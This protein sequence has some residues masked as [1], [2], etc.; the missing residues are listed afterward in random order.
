MCLHKLLTMNGRQWLGFSL[1]VLSCVAW[2]VMP[3]LAFFSLE[4]ERLAVYI[5]GLF[6]FA[7]ITWWLAMPLLGP[8][9]LSF[10]R[11]YY[12]KIK[13]YCL[14]RIGARKAP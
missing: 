1:L 2:G 3:F 12:V 10:C 7:E 8:E 9:V 13:N 6:I 5:A 4:G 11:R 14:R